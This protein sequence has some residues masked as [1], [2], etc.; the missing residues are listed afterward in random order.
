MNIGEIATGVD[1]PFDVN[2]VIEIPRG[3]AGEGRAGK[4]VRGHV[5]PVRRATDVPSDGHE[6]TAGAG[7]RRCRSAEH[8]G[9]GPK[10]MLRAVM[11]ALPAQQAT[12]L[13]HA[14]KVRPTDTSGRTVP[15][16]PACGH[17]M[18]VTWLIGAKS[19]GCVE[20]DA[21]GRLSTSR[22][23]AG[24]QAMSPKAREIPTNHN[25]RFAPVI[26]PTGVEALAVAAQAWLSR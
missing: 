1:P 25:P 14:S 24:A 12:G 6:V 15:V 5:G 3:R 16:M 19:P 8:D 20:G 4:G 9:E 21:E 11:D 26:H 17:D 7:H 10:V 22:G 2:A 13:P 23:N 18:G